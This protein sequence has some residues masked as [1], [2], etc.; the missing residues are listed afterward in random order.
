M[1]DIDH[2]KQ[3]NDQWG[4]A[5]GDTALWTFAFELRAQ[6]R[7]TDLVARWGGEELIVAFPDTD[8]AGAEFQLARLRGEIARTRLKNLDPS[9]RLS[10]SGGVG[11][12]PADGDDATA[13]IAAADARLLKAKQAGRNRVV[14]A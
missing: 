1:L 7:A 14:A 11:Q 9:I 13:L 4:H 6:T 5:A 10:F 2:F 3:F 12:F 8:T